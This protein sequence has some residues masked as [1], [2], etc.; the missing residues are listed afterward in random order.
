MGED[1]KK[2]MRELWR[3]A[4]ETGQEIGIGRLVTCD[5]CD[6]DYTDRS[7][8]GGFI[9][10]SY[11]YCPS[12]ALRCAPDIRRF[13]EG[14]LIRATCPAGVAFAEFVRQYQYRANTGSDSIRVTTFSHNKPP[15]DP[16]P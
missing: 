1:N 10:G 9:F 16:E 5:I 3:E 12:C 2:A 8:S 15:E 13:N 4:E 11:A 14:H 6:E 7:D